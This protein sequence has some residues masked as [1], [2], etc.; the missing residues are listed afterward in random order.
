MIA[1]SALAP[2]SFSRALAAISP[3]ASSSNTR[4]TSSIARSFWYCL[5]MAFLGFLRISTSISFVSPWRVKITGRR[6][7]NSG[8]IPNSRRSSTATLSRIFL[9]LSY[10][11]LRSA[12]KP[13]EAC[14]FSLFF[15]MPS[16]SGKAPA[17]IKRIF[18]VLTVVRGTMAFL[19]LA[20]TGTSTS[21]PSRSLSI[22]CCTASPLTSL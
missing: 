9:S 12:L 14:L 18:L 2:V 8:I 20:P 22:P 1:R 11:S 10:L 4:F 21:A 6:P 15:T 19:E 16:R 7:R 17:Q 13:M 3:R 5:T